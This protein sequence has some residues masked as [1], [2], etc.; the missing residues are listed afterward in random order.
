MVNLHFLLNMACEIFEI[1]RRGECV[2]VTG[3]GE[4]T[5]NCTSVIT[6]NRYKYVSGMRCYM[7]S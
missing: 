2:Q 7:G 3:L 5:L 4:W 6:Y 1:L